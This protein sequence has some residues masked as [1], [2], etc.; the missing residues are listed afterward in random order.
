M[1]PVHSLSVVLSVHVRVGTISVL[2]NSKLVRQR[3]DERGRQTNRSRPIDDRTVRKLA[4]PWKTERVHSLV[5]HGRLHKG[6]IRTMRPP[7]PKWAGR[8]YWLQDDPITRVMAGNSHHG[9]IVPPA[10][11]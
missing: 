2:R 7:H 9:A 3:V 4:M 1:D 5:R 11:L 8:Y 10:H 6:C